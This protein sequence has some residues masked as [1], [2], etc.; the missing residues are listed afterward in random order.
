M[1]DVARDGLLPN[2]QQQQGA[3]RVPAPD[4]E[5]EREISNR[6]C[7]TEDTCI[8]QLSVRLT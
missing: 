5:T 3:D 8:K 4:A 7:L 1:A 2:T 6:L